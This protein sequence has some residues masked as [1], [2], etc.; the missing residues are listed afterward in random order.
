MDIRTVITKVEEMGELVRIQREVDPDTELASVLKRIDELSY[1]PVVLFEK[2]KGSGKVRVLGH[3]YSETKRLSRL[4]NLPD[5]PLEYKKRVLELW[6]NA[7]KPKMVKT[8]P[9]KE[10]VVLNDG[11]SFD[12][13]KIIPPIIGAKNSP[14]N[15]RYYHPL[16]VT[17]HPETG[18][19]N[20]GIYRSCVQSPTEIS[21]NLRPIKHGGFHFT[22]AKE[23]DKKLPVAL[24]IDAAPQITMVA[25]TNIPYT[26]DEF[27]YAGGMMGEAVELVPCET[28]DLEVP[29]SAEIVIEGEILTP[30]KYGT[31]GPWPEFLGYLSDV[32]HPPI[33]SV[34]AV[35]FRD[36]PIN[37]VFIPS[38]KDDWNLEG[39]GYDVTL[40]SVVKNFA[41]DLVIDVNLT[42]GSFK[43]HHAIIQVRKSDPTH[44]PRNISV[45]LAAFNWA[46]WLDVV[47]LVDEDINIYNYEKI[48]WAISTRCDPSKQIHILP[49]GAGHKVNPIC[50][51]REST[52]GKISKGKMIIDA[53]IP[54]EYKNIEKIPGVK[55]FTVSEW[56]DVKLKDYLSPKDFE[57]W[58]GKTK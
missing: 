43:Y 39:L 34:T 25:T 57:K 49:V 17:K 15:R 29:A 3:L 40:Y 6:K 20:V 11:K 2:L 41:P 23:A 31:D 24:V 21:V 5:D 56:L 55:Y 47:I 14:K 53:T 52:D 12:I 44:E 37:Y 27:A 32:L 8:G 16:V 18:D 30:Y 10:N 26:H 58:S 51:V 35:T 38:T 54:W 46:S 13:T 42:S 50:G 22:A 33:M 28:I 1:R 48:D 36:N 4:L 7:I 19:R 45:A 9:C